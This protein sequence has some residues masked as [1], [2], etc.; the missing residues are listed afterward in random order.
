M[1]VINGCMGWRRGVPRLCH[2]FLRGRAQLCT[3]VLNEHLTSQ[4][5]QTMNHVSEL[6]ECCFHAYIAKTVDKAVIEI[7]LPNYF[8][9]APLPHGRQRICA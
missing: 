8:T 2:F 7:Q 6:N 9:S 4:L 1:I 3:L 5:G